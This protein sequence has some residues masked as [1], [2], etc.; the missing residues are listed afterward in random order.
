M[1]LREQ[2]KE[3]YVGVGVLEPCTTDRRT[4]REDGEETTRESRT[5]ELATEGTRKVR[6]DL[7]RSGATRVSRDRS[8][9]GINGRN[10]HGPLN[11]SRK[12][13]DTRD[14][15]FPDTEQVVRDSPVGDCVSYASVCDK[16]FT[17]TLDYYIV[18]YLPGTI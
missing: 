13:S 2:L 6:P 18:L 8:T 5:G 1:F 11:R 4:L 9:K 12:R 15:P 16:L 17:S 3:V 7:G 14:T 10:T